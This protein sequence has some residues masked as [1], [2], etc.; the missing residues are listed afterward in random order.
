MRI[1][2]R[3]PKIVIWNTLIP[4]KELDGRV[5]GYILMLINKILLGNVLIASLMIPIA[6]AVAL[7]VALEIEL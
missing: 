7:E 2:E 6:I 3:I 4:Y 5:T 1:F